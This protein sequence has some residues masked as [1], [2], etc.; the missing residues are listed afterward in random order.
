MASWAFL[1]GEGG[2]FA[3]RPLNMTLAVPQR[4]PCLEA[5]LESC[6]AVLTI[7]SFSGNL[8]GALLSTS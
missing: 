5:R 8:N 7:V 3:E 4:D 2:S 6:L 1:E